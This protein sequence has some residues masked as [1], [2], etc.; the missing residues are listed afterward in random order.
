MDRHN[1][2]GEE[3]ISRLLV[4]F[5]V[6]AIVGMLVNALY[7]IVDRLY[8]GN[9]KDVGKYAIT[10]VGLTL[11]LSTIIMA[12]G[13]LIGI[14]AAAT[15]SIKLGK[16]MKKDAEHILGNAFVMLI[17]TSVF[18]TTLGL[19]FSEDILIAFGAS[20][21]TLQY[22]VEYIRII[23]I[24]NIFNMVSFGL[25]HSI[26]SDGNPKIAMISMLIGAIMNTILDPIFI[27]GFNM[28]VS[29]AALATIL[30]QLATAIWVLS[31]FMG[32][33]SILKLKKENFK[34]DKRILLTIFSIG[35]SP[36]SM[37][38]AASVV[39][40]TFNKSLGTYGG[41]YAIGA[42]TVISSIIMIFLMPVF[43]INQGSQPIIG[44]NYGA[45]KFKRVKD[46]VKYAAIAATGFVTLGFLAV[47]LFPAQVIGTFN[48]DPEIVQTG[49]MGMRIYLSM[50]P[51]I[52][53]Q[54]IFTNY[55][56]AIGKAK[57]SMFLSLLRQ[58]I[59]L[60][61]LLIIMPK[62]NGLG[63]RGV[64]MAAPIADI[65]SVVITYTIFYFE[66]KSYKGIKEGKDILPEAVGEISREDEINIPELQ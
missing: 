4:Q 1:R 37:Q 58:V 14:G 41:D 64:W 66:M 56:Q 11:P 34:L 27:F 53:A 35:I 46:T 44:F 57:V 25:N 55:F 6:P 36:F 16:N 10:G 31:Y 28:G 8:I 61:P 30:S 19:I 60:I 38:L 2:L 20:E 59:L 23:L 48:R 39:Q 3:K 40:I 17:I 21:N 52:G 7:N 43:G 15:I 42:M 18:I 63:L 33:K 24:G 49:I 9:I 32:S 45:K 5:S 54:I 13:M 62:I 51:F 29:G 50:I 65:T 22:A 47:Q 12:F 26:R